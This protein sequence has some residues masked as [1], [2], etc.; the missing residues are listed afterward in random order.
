[1]KQYNGTLAI[2]LFIS[3]SYS[4][5][6][7]ISEGYYPGNNFAIDDYI[8]AH[9]NPNFD[10]FNEH[11]AR[12]VIAGLDFDQDGKGEI[13]FTIDEGITPGGFDPGLVG[14]YLYEANPAS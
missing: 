12:N 10:E 6:D 13:L 7:E 11:G 8:I 4:Q 2:F 14:I 9:D 5:D 3:L 1:M